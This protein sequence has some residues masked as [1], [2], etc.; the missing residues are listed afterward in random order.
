M[1]GFESQWHYLVERLGGPI[2]RALGSRFGQP[3]SYR[4]NFDSLGVNWEAQAYVS[5]Y[6]I[7]HLYS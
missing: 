3:F 1:V 5:I 2:S 6:A 4:I 7:F